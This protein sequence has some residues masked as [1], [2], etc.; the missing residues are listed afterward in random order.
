MAVDSTTPEANSE[1]QSKTDLDVRICK[2]NNGR[3][4]LNEEAD[5][6][7]DRNS[8]F[9]IQAEVHLSDAADAQLFLGIFS[10]LR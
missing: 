7:V 2:M 1:W 8:A 10:K 6:V 3:T 4:Q 9:I 5:H